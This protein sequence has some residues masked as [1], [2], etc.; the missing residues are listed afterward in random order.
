MFLVTR[1]RNW[2]EKSEFVKRKCVLS[3]LLYI[4][5]SNCAMELF[6]DVILDTLSSIKTKR[7]LTTVSDKNRTAFNDQGFMPS[8]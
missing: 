1:Q 8:S 6:A 7:T 2:T 4:Y 3:E 5:I